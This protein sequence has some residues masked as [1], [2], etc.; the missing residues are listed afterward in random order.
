MA[1]LTDLNV[2]PYYD[3]FS[4][5]NNF[6]RTLF[7]PGFAIQARELTQL[8]STLQNQIEQGFSHMFKDGT[9]VIPGALTCN[10]NGATQ[11]IKL[12]SSF[13]GETIDILQYLNDDVPVI[14]TGETTGVKF[15][16]SFATAASSTEPATL[17][18]VYTRGAMRKAPVGTVTPDLNA[19]ESTTVS[20]RLQDSG[21]YNSF[22]IG[23]NLSANVAVQHGSTAFAAD[24]VSITT[25][26]T[27]TDI[28]TGRT[29]AGPTGVLGTGTTG[30]VSAN[31]VLAHISEGIYFVR[32]HFIEVLPQTIAVSKYHEKPS[33]KIG[34]RINEEIITPENDISLLDN[35]TGSSNY[36]AKG[37][38]R[39]KISLTLAA[40]DV[41]STDDSD[42]I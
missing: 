31:C 27:E 6:V 19:L 35:A 9:M 36:A 3:D 26:T 37:A 42:F 28:N 10:L 14:L 7:R 23:E 22:I 15:A 32:G 12:Q 20:A 21:G 4:S 11:F 16:V 40:I 39:L 29:F 2:A 18:G 25:E 24:T 34:L 38:H 5:E 13:G 1:E 33:V 41:T 8:Q 30:P 17:F